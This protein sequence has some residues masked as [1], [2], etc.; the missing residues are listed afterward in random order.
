MTIETLFMFML[1]MDGQIYGL[2]FQ[3]KIAFINSF[4][5]LNY[6]QDFSSVTGDFMVLTI[7]YLFVLLLNKMKKQFKF[8]TIHQLLSNIISNLENQNHS[9]FTGR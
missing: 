7:F 4:I 3:I 2:L 1:L 6:F 9:Y 8:T 5:K